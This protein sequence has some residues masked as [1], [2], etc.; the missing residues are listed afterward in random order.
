MVSIQSGLPLR[1]PD[2][3]DLRPASFE[4]E[5]SANLR[6][7]FLRQVLR[8]TLAFGTLF[9]VVFF[10]FWWSGAAIRFGASR[11]ADRPVATW[12]L[13]GAVRSA[14]THQPVP[15]ASIDDDP[16]G[17]PPFFHADA[18]Q[19]GVFELLTLPEPHRVRVSAPGYRTSTIDVGR[20]WFLWLPQG[21]EH[22]DILLSPE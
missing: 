7:H 3:D 22:Q 16:S 14:A 12:R 21:R 1:G 19:S 10:A 4:E 2:P 13:V 20:V 6:R 5:E 9:A 17:Q 18:D 15:W 11:V 8:G